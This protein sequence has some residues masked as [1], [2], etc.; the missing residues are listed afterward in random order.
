MGI[1]DHTATTPAGAAPTGSERAL[2]DA[3]L[4]VAAA[5][6]GATLDH[7]QFGLYPDDATVPMVFRGTAW[8]QMTFVHERRNDGPPLPGTA[9]RRVLGPTPD[10]AR[11][12]VIAT[13]RRAY[14]DERRPRPTDIATPST[15]AGRQEA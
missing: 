4:A 15:R 7:V 11:V 6:A 10:Q 3:L 13:W 14:F 9:L 2:D 8:W 5:P 12:Q 1:N